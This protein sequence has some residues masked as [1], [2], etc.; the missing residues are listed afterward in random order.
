MVLVVSLLPEKAYSNVLV[1]VYVIEAPPPTDPP[2]SDNGTSI[3]KERVFEIS[4]A[5]EFWVCQDLL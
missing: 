1:V 2:N 3:D 5:T 4:L